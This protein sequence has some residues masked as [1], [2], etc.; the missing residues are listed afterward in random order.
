MSNNVF[1]QYLKEHLLEVKQTPTHVSNL[2]KKF[3]IG[4]KTK[5]LNFQKVGPKNKQLGPNIAQTFC[6]AIWN[7]E[8]LVSTCVVTSKRIGQLSCCKRMTNLGVIGAQHPKN[9]GVAIQT[10]EMRPNPPKKTQKMVWQWARWLKEP[11]K[12]LVSSNFSN[13]AIIWISNST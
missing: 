4:D 12:D 1:A 10:I 9:V 13:V 2:L 5:P 6:S 11:P 8:V 7:G 3:A